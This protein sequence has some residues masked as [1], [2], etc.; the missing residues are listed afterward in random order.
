MDWNPDWCWRCQERPAPP[1]RKGRRV[2]ADCCW[3][4]FVDLDVPSS[5]TQLWWSYP[6]LLCWLCQ[7]GQTE[8]DDDLGLCQSCRRS[9]LPKRVAA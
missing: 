2:C 7:R 5:T 8:R 1:D 6:L 4:I 9:F 3:E